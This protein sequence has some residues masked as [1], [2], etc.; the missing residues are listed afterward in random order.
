MKPKSIVV[1]AFLAASRPAVADDLGVFTQNLE[2]VVPSILGGSAIEVSY[3]S[4]NRY[5]TRAVE[6][7]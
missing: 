3:Q 2:L 6:P 7:T 4:G 5:L 1:A